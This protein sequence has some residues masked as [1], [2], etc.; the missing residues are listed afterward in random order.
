M[1]TKNLC[2]SL[3]IG[4]WLLLFSTSKAQSNNPLDVAFGDPFVL[5]DQETDAYYMYGT[6]GVE[7]SF[8]AYSSKDLKQWKN[9]GTV[10]TAQQDKSWGTKDFWAPEV[11]KRGGKYYMFYSAHWKE[12]PNDEL[13]NYRIGIATSTNPT[14]PF[15]DLTGRPLFDPGYPI[16]DGNVYFAEDGR[17]YLYYSRCCYKN[18]VQSEI[19]AWAKQ[20]GMFDEIEESWI[21]GVEL[22]SDFSHVIGEPT[23]LL[24]PPI[25]RD[26]KQ[27]EWESRSV[28]SGEV[29][30]RWTEGSYLFKH[31]NLYYMMY[32]ANHF[33]GENYAVGYATASNPLGPFEKSA[34]NPILQKNISNGGIVSG[35]GHNSLLK[36]K[37]GKVWCV[38]HARTTKT[39]SQRL[40]FLDE[41]KILPN[42][43][44]IVDGPTVKP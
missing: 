38:Y 8:V 1:I 35:T 13:E 9:R 44:L 26:D 43:Q 28:T 16:I 3:L 11:Y 15:I 31:N 33:G 30:R 7:N 6:G 21:Y 32:S 20:Q 5:Y 10:Y 27:S 24:R 34:T 39:G 22:A 40:V 29:N 4:C 36:D 37:E 23:L 17:L 25:S 2:L 18:P 14:G 19:A 42:G 41:L 12:N